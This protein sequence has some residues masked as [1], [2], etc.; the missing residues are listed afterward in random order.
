[1]EWRRGGSMR[2][3][4][5]SCEGGCCVCFLGW[6]VLCIAMAQRWILQEYSWG[7]LAEVYITNTTHL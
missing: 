2:L 3:L 6:A 4:L 7:E 5:W 1:M